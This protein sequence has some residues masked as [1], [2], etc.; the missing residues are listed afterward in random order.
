MSISESLRTEEAS[1]LL[2]ELLRRGAMREKQE[3]FFFMTEPDQAAFE[4][5]SSKGLACL[6]DEASGRIAATNKAA[7][8]LA[9]SQ[10]FT[11]PTSI[12]KYVSMARS[13]SHVDPAELSAFDLL[14]SL[15][16][17]GWSERAT[18]GKSKRLTPYRSDGEKLLF[19]DSCSKL[20]SKPYLVCL[21]QADKL[22]AKGISEVHH[23]Q[24]EMYYKALLHCEAEDAA[25]ITPNCAGGYYREIL[26]LPGQDPANA[27][28]RGASV[29]IMKATPFI[30]W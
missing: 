17:S 20:I 25:R 11:G 2:S 7:Q 12:C 5:L 4:E 1:V 16:D 23:F 22:F 30:Q 24:P 14:V 6:L 13:A 9:V 26:R 10:K 19:Y 29:R 8:R 28:Q 21:L 27:Q 3:T 18:A 15:I